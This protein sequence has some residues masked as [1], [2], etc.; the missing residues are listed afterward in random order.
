MSDREVE[1][2]LLWLG[3]ASGKLWLGEASLQAGR[4]G[5]LCLRISW[6]AEWRFLMANTA[7]HGITELEMYPS[8]IPSGSWDGAEQKSAP[9]GIFYQ[10]LSENKI[11]VKL[12]T[13]DAD[14]LVGLRC[15]LEKALPFLGWLLGPVWW[16]DLSW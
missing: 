15:S 12:V 13:G 7:T 5:Q 14:I 6:G 11:R 10:V 9:L 2:L 3:L 8:K 4:W 16:L 1:S